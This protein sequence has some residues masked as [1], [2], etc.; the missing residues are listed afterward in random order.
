M[1]LELQET[2]IYRIIDANLNRYKEGIR[3]V[4]DT[5]RYGFN[6]KSLALKLKV[7]RHLANLDSSQEFIEFRDAS[8]DVLKHTLSLELNRTN[9][10]DIIIAN[11]KRSQE[12]SRVLEELFKIVDIE[13]SEKFKSAR[14]QLYTLEKEILKLNL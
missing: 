11:L 9:L 1:S 7:L 8:S 4:E 2:K 14:Y 12:S 6:E 3:V 10:K 13:I 5:L